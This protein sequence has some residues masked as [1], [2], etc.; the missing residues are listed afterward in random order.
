M[1]ASARELQVPFLTPLVWR[2]WGANPRP[3]APEAD[4][5][6]TRR[7]FIKQFGTC[8]RK[9]NVGMNVHNLGHLVDGVRQWGPLWAYS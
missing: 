5:L 7:L 1:R 6:T 2:D 9:E 4:T 3:T 8:Y